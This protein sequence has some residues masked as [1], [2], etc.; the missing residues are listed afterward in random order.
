M[1]KRGYH[2]WK[3]I[4]VWDT[5]CHRI[6]ACWRQ[7][8]YKILLE[9]SKYIGYVSDV[10]NMKSVSETIAT[11]HLSFCLP[12]DFFLSRQISNSQI[13]AQNQDLSAPPIF[14]FMTILR[15]PLYRSFW[16]IFNGVVV[17]FH[18]HLLVLW[19]MMLYL[20]FLCENKLIFLHVCI[21]TPLPRRPPDS[22][23]NSRGS[24]YVVYN[25]LFFFPFR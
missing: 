7:S 15:K 4:I 12:C 8:F 6:S 20:C 14:C 9:L 11:P 1:M 17:L 3:V 16:P 13:P 19:P 2:K 10:I 18:R 21:Q 5:R 22:K 23:P 24:V 25:F